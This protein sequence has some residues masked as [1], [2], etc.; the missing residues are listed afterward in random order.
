MN[1]LERREQI[2]R[3]GSSS[4]Q[5]TVNRCG[6]LRVDASAQ[7][8]M[9]LLSSSRAPIHKIRLRAEKQKKGKDTQ[10]FSRVF[11]AA[12]VSSTI[13]TDKNALRIQMACKWDISE[14]QVCVKLFRRPRC[15][16][17]KESHSE[18]VPA[19]SARRFCLMVCGFNTRIYV[20]VFPTQASSFCSVLT[21]ALGT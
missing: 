19:H 4:N 9:W 2:A 8:R 14:G 16:P 12:L 5:G 17:E 6:T 15:S 13:H 20:R 11:N 18:L 1:A 10:R 21:K 7:P 3:G